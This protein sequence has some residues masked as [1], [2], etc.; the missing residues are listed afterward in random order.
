MVFMGVLS[1]T[2]RFLAK[3]LTDGFKL[4]GLILHLLALLVIVDS[5]LLQGLQHLLHLLLR[6]LILCLQAVQL[7]LEVLMITTGGSQELREGGTSFKVFPKRRI[8]NN[9]H[10][11]SLIFDQNEQI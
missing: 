9:F 10:F 6:G 8:S 7:S 1:L 3:L 11:T 4:L 5:Q 2:Y